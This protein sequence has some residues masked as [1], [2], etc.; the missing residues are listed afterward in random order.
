M[1]LQVS[2]PAGT[3]I[4]DAAI[5]AIDFAKL[6]RVDISFSFNGINI[7]ITPDSNVNDIEFY[8]NL[9]CKTHAG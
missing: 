4:K 1:I 8:Y 6:N 9:A 2:F 7:F 3:S 5:D